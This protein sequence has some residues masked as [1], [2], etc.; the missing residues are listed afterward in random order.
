MQPFSGPGGDAVKVGLDASL[1]GSGPRG[2]R[3]PVLWAWMTHSRGLGDERH[4][5]VHEGTPG[6]SNPRAAW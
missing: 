2:L 3:A 1:S 6:L 4:V 5:A